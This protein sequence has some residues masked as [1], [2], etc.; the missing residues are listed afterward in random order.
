MVDRLGNVGGDFSSCLEGACDSGVGSIK[1]K[2]L[3]VVTVKWLIIF[4]KKNQV[5]QIT[6]YG[7]QER[8]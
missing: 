1:R 3:R 4:G 7:W 2:M 8:R 6:R 5:K